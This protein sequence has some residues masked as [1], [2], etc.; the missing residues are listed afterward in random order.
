MVEFQESES[1]NQIEILKFGG[2]YSPIRVELNSARA[3][4]WLDRLGGAEDNQADFGRDAEADGSADGAQ[5]TVDVDMGH[6]RRG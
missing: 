4:R 5:T 6:R 3:S 1:K 2:I